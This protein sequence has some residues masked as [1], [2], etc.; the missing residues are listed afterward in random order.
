MAI[1]HR[2]STEANLTACR[3]MES[4]QQAGNGGFATSTLSHQCRRLPWVQS[5]GGIFYSV[6]GLG[7][8]EYSYSAQW[9]I[10]LQMHSLQN[11]CHLD[12]TALLFLK[13]ECLRSGRSARKRGFDSSSIPKLINAK[14]AHSKAMHNPAG[15]NCHH[16]PTMSAALFCAQYNI[17]PQLGRD[18]SPS[19]R[20]SRA[21]S[22]PTAYTNVPTKVEAISDTSLVNISEE[23]IRKGLSP[24]ARAAATNSRSFNESVCAR[25][26]RAP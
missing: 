2:L 19:P 7:W 10:F 9:K 20:N 24:V 8:T 25:N 11:G 26:T 4:P 6:Y 1:S 15:T 21:T 23:I 16:F 13:N 14:P 5:Q 17:T 18:V 22:A 3:L 12:A